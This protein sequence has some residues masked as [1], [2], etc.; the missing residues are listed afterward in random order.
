MVH[1]ARG[2]LERA[3]ADE[4]QAIAL[5]PSD[6]VAYTYRA[7]AYYES[8]QPQQAIDDYTRA[9]GLDRGQ[10]E[11]FYG[12]GLAHA[13]AGDV[14]PAVADLTR[15]LELAPQAGDRASVEEL[16]ARLQGESAPT[17][18]G[19]SLNLADLP[20]GFEAVPPAN[21][22]LAAGSA[23]DLGFAIEGSFAFG[24]RERFE[25]VWGFTTRLAGER[26]RADFDANLQLEEL[27]A[28]LS[29]GIRADEVLEQRELEDLTGLGEGALGLSAVFTSGD[30]R[31]R[32]D[33]VAFRSGNRG[34]LVFVTYRDGAEP[35][36]GVA[37]LARLLHERGAS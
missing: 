32:L 6:P 20:A 4:S 37:D 30:T 19:V 13:S 7:R 8:R 34:V 3:I 27:V 26:E 28:F 11:A 21:L 2:D 33:G 24:A 16:I 22:G 17:E 10:S 31:T 15:Y 9:L 25:L 29:G 18:A 14:E 23:I 36:V 5:D 1:L 12:R 35:S